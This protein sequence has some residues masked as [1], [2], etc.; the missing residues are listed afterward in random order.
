MAKRE[1][2]IVE[3]PFDELAE[4]SVL[5][6]II[7]EPE[8]IAI[9]LEYSL[10]EEDFYFPHHRE[11]YSLL[12]GI[13]QERGS[14]WDDVVFLDYAQKKG[15]QIER[16]L[17]YSLVQE[18]SVGSLFESAVAIVK[19]KSGL[20]KA[21]ELALRI[22]KAQDL[23]PIKDAIEG[24]ENIFTQN[25]SEF[26]HIGKLLSAEYERLTKARQE[27]R[28]ITGITSGFLDLDLMLTGFQRG[29]L[30]VVGARPGM[31]KSSFMLSLALNMA[32]EN[33]VG[34]FSLE[35]TKEELTQ[36]LLAMSTGIGL[37]NIRTGQL[38]DED[39]ELITQRALE[40]RRLN[41]YI[42]DNPSMSVIDLRVAIRQKNL[43]VIFVDYLQLLKST[44]RY[45]TR[46]EEVADISRGL[47]AL[48]KQMDVC[49][50]ALAQLNRQ[51]EGRA[52]KRP[53]LSDLRESGA[54]EM[55]ADIVIFLHRPEYY[56][57]NP[58]EEEK[59]I[60][61]VIVAKN[62]QGAVGVLKMRFVPETT[63]FIPLTHGQPFDA[64][65]EESEDT[66]DLDF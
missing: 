31:G 47:K 55:D 50:I 61:E 66:G 6:G 62:R 22:L 65:G 34:I 16:T 42:H 45:N 9:A 46:Q 43:D 10:S 64:N 56:K 41:L 37:R 4:R 39:M 35:M 59:G 40:L 57:S 11:L 25:T 12:L 2:I 33:K 20:R 13:Y 18:G 21:R 49:V 48:A 3:E 54:I 5:G 38:S 51:V 23:V 44:R 29:Q 24:L 8:Q 28:L 15:F 7:V 1:E 60:A 30:V 26:D 63:A 53:T 58:S 27:N 32:R 17:L 19:E 36:R 14:D 52:S